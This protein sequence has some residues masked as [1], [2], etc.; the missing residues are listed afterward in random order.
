M[1]SLIQGIGPQSLL[2]VVAESRE[3]LVSLA[4]F[5]SFQSLYLDEVF[6][7]FLLLPFYHFVKAI[8]NYCHTVTCPQTTLWSWERIVKSKVLLFSFC[9]CIWLKMKPFRHVIVLCLSHIHSFTSCWNPSS[10][11]GSL[12]LAQ[13]FSVGEPELNPADGKKRTCSMT[14]KRRNW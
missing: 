9:S 12:M 1:W 8:W 5:I 6:T 7:G 3:R 10:R 4:T 2:S 11:E 13:S 14:V